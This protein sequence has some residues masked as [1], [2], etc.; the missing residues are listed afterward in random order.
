M[1]GSEPLTVM[2]DQGS[3][4][5]ETQLLYFANP[6]VLLFGIGTKSANT[7]P[8]VPSVIVNNYATCLPMP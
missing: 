3:Q 2:L 1:A 5:E 8:G 4:L 7:S 6:R